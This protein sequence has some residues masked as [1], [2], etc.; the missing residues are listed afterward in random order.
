MKVLPR[1]LV[2]WLT[3]F[4]GCAP[5][6]PPVLSPGMEG[7]KPAEKRVPSPAKKGQTAPREYKKPANPPLAEP[8]ENSQPT[9]GE[10][11]I[12]L[13]EQAKT[14]AGAGEAEQAAATLERALRIEPK[15]PWLWHRIAVLRL[16]QGHW[17]EAIDLATKSNALASG[18]R[19]LLGGNWK[20]ISMA[21]EG[22]GDPEGARDAR[23]KS[24]GYFQEVGE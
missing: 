8:S 21:L 5:M 9:A 18:H 16:Q 3:C 1:I 12:A 7:A 14:Q 4:A 20:V 17:E 2:L 6:L 13:L 11:V 19:R 22:L 23:L 24:E 10:A 15:N